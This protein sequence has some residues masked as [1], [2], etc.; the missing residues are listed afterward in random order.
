MN[1]TEKM[2]I[3]V[4][5]R[6]QKEFEEVS[7]KLDKTAIRSVVD[8]IEGNLIVDE[9]VRSKHPSWNVD[10]YGQNVIFTMNGKATGFSIISFKNLLEVLNYRRQALKRE[11]IEF[12][13][14]KLYEEELYEIESN[15]QKAYDKWI[16]EM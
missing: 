6:T 5:G 16:H 8:L 3:N 14:E 2:Y 4:T 7:S 1:E 15:L 9:V 11:K 10:F 13:F 12:Y